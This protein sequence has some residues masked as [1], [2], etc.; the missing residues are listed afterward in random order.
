MKWADH[1]SNHQRSKHID[2]RYYF[3]RDHMKSKTIIV[4]WLKTQELWQ[5]YA[6]AEESKEIQSTILSKS[7]DQ[8]GIDLID[9]SNNEFN[10]Y[11]WILTGID[12][13]S[14]KAYAVPM[15]NKEN[16]N[17]NVAIKKVIN[18]SHPKSIRSDNGSEFISQSFKKILDD[19]N[20]KQIFSLPGK[21][22]SNGQIERFNGIIKNLINKDMKYNGSY[23]WYSPLEKLID[24]YNDTY[25]SVIKMTPNEAENITDKDS[26]DK[27]K[28]NIYKNVV[29][30]RKSLIT[31]KFKIG[32]F[33]RLKDENEKTKTNWSKEIF[34]ISKVNKRQK[35]YTSPSYYIS[36][37]SENSIINK[38]YYDNDLLLVP[39][40]NGKAIVKNKIDEEKKYEISK[41]L[42][43]KLKNG[44]GMYLVKWK[45]YKETTWEP[46]KL[47]YADVPKMI[48]KF[49]KDN[50]IT[51]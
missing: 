30:K 24:N 14:K 1:D 18:E 9:M 49:D 13:F 50:D 19:N 45:G 46:R 6:P 2:I 35:I 28:Q 12:L 34:K 7:H 4:E 38:K 36:R 11:K 8:I 33:V 37:L 51:F 25:Q 44:D 15:K 42:E 43:F 39:D 47:L 22:Q 32:D 21:P 41:L 20:I 10:G 23:D 26:L 5:L 3:I 16:R 27:I 40:V 17:V 48:K 31:S 29:S